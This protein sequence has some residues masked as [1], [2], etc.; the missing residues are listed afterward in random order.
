MNTTAPWWSVHDAD[1]AKQ[2]KHS[3]FN[4]SSIHHM[5]MQLHIYGTII[6]K[7]LT[8]NIRST[9][10]QC[11]HD[12]GTKICFTHLSRELNQRNFAGIMAIV[13]L[14]LPSSGLCSSCKLKRGQCLLEHLA[15]NGCA[16]C[17]FLRLQDGR[18]S[19]ISSALCALPCSDPPAFPA[20]AAAAIPLLTVPWPVISWVPGHNRA[21]SEEPRRMVTHSLCQ[22]VW[23]R[24][25]LIAWPKTLYLSCATWC[26]PE[27]A[28]L[29]GLLHM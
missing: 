24:C 13:D 12:T 22:D 9:K 29:G 28:G 2:K 7:Q 1:H 16:L 27:R 20:A 8:A 26:H 14:W 19:P 11:A 10:Y 3:T 17:P 6:P 25:P 4:Y 18:S 5:A 23:P 15:G 21:C